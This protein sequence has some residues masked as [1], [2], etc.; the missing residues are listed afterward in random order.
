[1]LGTKYPERQCFFSRSHITGTTGSAVDMRNFVDNAASFIIHAPPSLGAA[2][3]VTFETTV[4][5]PSNDCNPKSDGWGAMNA[6]GMCEQTAALS[7]V[8]DPAD[9]KYSSTKG[10]VVRVPI[11]CRSAFVRGNLSAETAGVTVDVVGAARRLDSV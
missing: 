10:M 5:D 3:T 1:M 6:E 4:H 11:Q 9:P 7:V 8:L 2:V